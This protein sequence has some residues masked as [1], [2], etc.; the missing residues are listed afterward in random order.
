ME[1]FHLSL[2]GRL[3]SMVCKCLDLSGLLEMCNLLT[4]GTDHSQRPT[5]SEKQQEPEKSF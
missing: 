1:K 3:C 4:Q 5:F 2:K